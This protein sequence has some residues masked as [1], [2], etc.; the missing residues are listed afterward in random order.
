LARR[1]LNI[2]SFLIHSSRIST[3]GFWRQNLGLKP[4]TSTSPSAG[5]TIFVQGLK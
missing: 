5:W 4:P 1:R 2:A 3:G